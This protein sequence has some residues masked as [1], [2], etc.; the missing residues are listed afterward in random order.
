MSFINPL[1]RFY[2]LDPSPPFPVP[3]GEGDGRGRVKKG[4]EGDEK[5]HGRARG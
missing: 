1:S 4:Q 3:K 5:S 2:L